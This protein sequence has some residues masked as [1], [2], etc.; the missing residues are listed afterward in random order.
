M[1][2]GVIVPRVN[3]HRLTDF[4]FA[5]HLQDGGHDVSSRRKVL[6]SIEWKRSFCPAQ[7]LQRPTVSGHILTAAA[8]SLNPPP[9]PLRFHK[10]LF[11]AQTI[12]SLHHHAENSRKYERKQELVKSQGF[13]LKLFAATVLVVGAHIGRCSYRV[14]CSDCAISLEL[15]WKWYSNS[16]YVMWQIYKWLI[17][18]NKFALLTYGKGGSE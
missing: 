4:R 14:L 16:I 15:L 17:G 1:K 18:L 7:M 11:P 12:H 2:F 3:S 13:F 10:F 5:S 6:P 9:L 8:K